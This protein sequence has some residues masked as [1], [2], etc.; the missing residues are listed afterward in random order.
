MSTSNAS[1]PLTSTAVPIVALTL[2]SDMPSRVSGRRRRTGAPAVA[3]ERARRV[4]ARAGEDA[5]EEFAAQGLVGVAGGHDDGLA[6]GVAVGVLDEEVHVAE[7]GGLL[8]GEVLLDGPVDEV[9]ASGDRFAE[10]AAALEQF[11]QHLSRRDADLRHRGEPVGDEAFDHRLGEFDAGAGGQLPGDVLQ[12]PD[13]LVAFEDTGNASFGVPC[14][15]KHFERGRRR[16][17]GRLRPRVR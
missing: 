9:D 5:G 6:P 8:G 3:R 13:L 14:L 2:A 11:V 15:Q 17:R 16:S 4:S 10:D 7:V 12:D 1:E